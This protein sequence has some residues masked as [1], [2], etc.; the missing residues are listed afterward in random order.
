MLLPDGRIN[1]GENPVNLAGVSWSGGYGRPREHGPPRDTAAVSGAALLA[2][3]EDFL[4]I[5]GMCPLFFMYVDDT[6]LAWR[7]RLGGRRV[8]YCPEAAVEHAYEFDKGAHK[9]FYL[10]RNRTF[11]LVGNLQLRTLAL[12]LPL[13]LAT[14]LVILARA[15]R[16]G[17]LREKLHAWADVF[18]RL[19][20][21]MRWRGAVQAT[22]RVPDRRVLAGFVA[23]FE[24]DLLDVDLPPW[25][26]TAL[27]LYRR[28]L[29]RLL[30]RG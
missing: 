27:D 21:L 22:R 23:G 20:A 14:E 26:N 7:M 10:E 13:L 6:D 2:R 30:A 4:A 16:E 25:V 28:I 29:L 1:A 12:L 3:R 5:G 18:A 15:A 24:T 17:W 8:R 19:P 11:A 9:W